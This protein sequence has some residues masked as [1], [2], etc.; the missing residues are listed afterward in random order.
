MEDVWISGLHGLY[1][2]I[3]VITL[4]ICRLDQWNYH[5]L[6]WVGHQLTVAAL[7]TEWEECQVQ[8]ILIYQLLFSSGNST[9]HW[10]MRKQFAF[11]SENHLCKE[12]SPGPVPDSIAKG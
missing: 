8:L 10:K 11:D 6:T 1:M 3:I 5:Y 9:V 4:S 7:D 12:S 2:E